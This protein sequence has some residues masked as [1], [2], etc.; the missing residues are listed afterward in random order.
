MRKIDEKF[1]SENNPNNCHKVNILFNYLKNND[2]GVSDYN[3]EDKYNFTDKFNI[4]ILKLENVILEDIYIDILHFN[5]FRGEKI[6][7]NGILDKFERSNPK[8]INTKDYNLHKIKYV[9]NNKTRFSFRQIM[10]FKGNIFLIYEFHSEYVFINFEDIK[11]NIYNNFRLNLII[12]KDINE[13][14]IEKYE[15]F[16]ISNEIIL[17]NPIIKDE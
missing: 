15:F 4:D 13:Y 5:Q 12:P 9:K 8:I 16:K 11:D 3:A 14:N 1:I 6:K 10:F 7:E 17:I 2:I